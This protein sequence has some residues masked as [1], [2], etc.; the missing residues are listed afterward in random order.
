MLLMD[1]DGILWMMSF[2]CMGVEVKEVGVGKER[3]GWEF[4]MGDVRCEWCCLMFIVFYLVIVNN[5]RW[6]FEFWLL[7]LGEY[8]RMS[9][10]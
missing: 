2:C 7:V 8:G 6:I 10:I 4:V 9:C 5:S 3:V 1:L